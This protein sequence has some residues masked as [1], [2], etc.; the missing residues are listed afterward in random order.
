MGGCREGSHGTAI[1]VR[2]VGESN[3]M[4]E[5]LAAMISWFLK[6]PSCLQGHI[7]KGTGPTGT[8]DFIDA[9]RKGDSIIKFFFEW[10][11]EFIKSD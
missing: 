9:N 2:W 11:A 4:R 10:W 8:Y 6:N 7:M 5:Q 3:P 1:A